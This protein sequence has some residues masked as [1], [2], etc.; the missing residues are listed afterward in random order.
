MS[1]SLFGACRQH[2]DAISRVTVK[3]RGEKRSDGQEEG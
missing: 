1:I 3:K 2:F